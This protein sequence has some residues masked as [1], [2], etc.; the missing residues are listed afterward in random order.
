MKPMGLEAIY[1]KKNLSKRRQKDA[2]YPYLLKM[3]PPS[4]SHDVWC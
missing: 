2:V 1:S 4:K 3:F